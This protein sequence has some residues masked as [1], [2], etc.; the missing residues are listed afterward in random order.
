M[1]STAGFGVPDATEIDLV[2]DLAGKRADYH[3]SLNQLLRHYQVAGNITKRQ[4]AQHELDAL[5]RVPHYHYLMTAELMPPTLI[6]SA[7]ID[8]ANILFN[9]AMELYKQ[10]GGLLIITDEDKLRGALNKFNQVIARF[11]SSNKIDDAAYRAGR[12]YEHFKDW[13]LAA[14]Y[15]QRCYQWNDVTAF[16]ARFRAAYI[17][18]QRLLKRTEAVT[19]YRLAVDREARYTKNI[20]FA[21]KRISELTRPGDIVTPAGAR[22]TSPG[23][24]FDTDMP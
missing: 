9:E 19:I 21:Q 8:D 3:Q 24:S 11:P 17:L 23:S 20:E 10:A 1:G 22:M 14:I 12:I 5:E 7:D 18:D 16:P 6:A 4:W 2:E 13:E 15:Y